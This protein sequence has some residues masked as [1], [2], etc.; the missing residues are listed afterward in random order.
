MCHTRVMPDG[1][2][3][4]GAQGNFPFD[5]AFA[6]ELRDRPALPGPAASLIA[7]RALHMLYSAPWIYPDAFP[8]IDGLDTS[9]MAQ[10]HEAVPPGVLSRHGTSPHAPAKVPDLIGIQDRRYFDAT[11]L[12]QHRDIGDLMRYAAMNQDGDLM[13]RYVDFVPVEALAK[14]PEDPSKLTGGRYSDEQLYAL[15]IFF[16]FAA[17]APANRINRIL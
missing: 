10:R 13:G 6:W 3:I 15:A 4:K 11:G 16:Y 7:R 5:R 9:E 2:A 1:S 12:T 14:A 17:S 8:E